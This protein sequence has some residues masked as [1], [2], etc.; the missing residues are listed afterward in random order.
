M[1][2]NSIGI[3]DWGIGGLSVYKEL[4]RQH[5]SDN[6]VYFSDSGYT[7]YGKSKK[8]ELIKRLNTIIQFFRNKNIS[9]VIIACNAAS[10]VLEPL[11]KLNPDIQLH[12]MLEAGRDAILKTKKN[13]S[14]S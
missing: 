4:R 12:G 2:S 7:P 11:Q 14:S 8:P 9:N 6:Y 10:T 1:K 5:N 3:I 13:L